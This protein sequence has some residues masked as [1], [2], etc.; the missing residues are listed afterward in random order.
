M[1]AANLVRAAGVVV[2][3]RSPVCSI[4]EYLL[5]QTSYGEHHWSP[6]KGHVDPGET[7]RIAAERETMEEAGLPTSAY[8]ID[9][10]FEHS[11]HYEAHGKPK[12][13][14]YWLARVHDADVKV[15]TTL[16]NDR[17]IALSCLRQVSLSHEHRDYKWAPIDVTLS[18]IHANHTTTAEVLRAADAYLAKKAE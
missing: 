12:R 5:L 14:V 18:T 13:V 11:I 2:Y 3:R 10:G 17:A 15:S 6:P 16:R 1:A 7:E 8:T 9:D 4:P